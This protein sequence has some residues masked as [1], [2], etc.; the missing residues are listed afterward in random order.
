MTQWQPH[1]LYGPWNSP[2]QNTGVGSRSLLQGNFPIQGLNPG[3]PHC[4]QIFYQLSHKGSP[5]ILE[6]VAY[7]FS[8]GSSQPRNRTR[9]SCIA[10]RF[11]TNRFFIREAHR[12]LSTAE[13]Y[14]KNISKQFTEKKMQMVTKLMITCQLCQQGKVQ[15]RAMMRK[16]F[17]FWFCFT[18]WVGK[19]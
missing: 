9:V 6:W 2:G 16:G 12:G 15:I 11:F 5:R 1:G 10:G 13:K 3:L 7:S 18:H 4:G 17:W 19:S 8:R 14:S